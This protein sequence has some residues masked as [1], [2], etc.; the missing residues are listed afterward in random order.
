M[1]GPSPKANPLAAASHMLSMIWPRASQWLIA[2]LLGTTITLLAV[3]LC[4]L[5]RWGT[6]PTTLQ[7]GT[8]PQYRIDVNNADRAELLQLPGVGASLAARIDDYRRNYGSFRTVEELAQVQGIG[9]TTL[10]RLRPW[11]RVSGVSETEGIRDKASRPPKPTRGS[12]KE[13]NL[14]GPIDIN[15]ASEKELQ[16]LPGIGP[17][18]AQRIIQARERSLFQSVEDLRRVSGFGPKTIEQ[19]R[20]YIM[21][22]RRAVNAGKGPAKAPAAGEPSQVQ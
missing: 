1:D 10:E 11:V 9:P 5:A 20:P 19:L 17:A 7:P 12:V 22:E 2:F 4:G 18:K 6:R 16:Q 21:L 8:K 3:H 14:R 15:E 13:E